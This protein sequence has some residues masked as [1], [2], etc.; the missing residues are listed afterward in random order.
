[1]SNGP[2]ISIRMES[3]RSYAKTM[4]SLHDRL[5]VITGDSDSGKSNIVRNVRS[6]IEGDSIGAVQ[7]FQR[8]ET[9]Q[10]S[11]RFDDVTISMNKGAGDNSY[12]ILSYSVPSPL[13][14]APVGD[15]Q[16]FTSVGSGVPD[17]VKRALNMGE[18]DLGNG[19]SLMLSI[20]Q[21]RGES[22]AID[23][24][25]ATCARIIGMVSGLDVVYG[26][27]ELSE[28]AR[29]DATKAKDT[30]R[31]ECRAAAVRVRTAARLAAR[32]RA[33][34]AGAAAARRIRDAGDGYEQAATRVRDVA[35][36]A[37]SAARW[38]QQASGRAERARTALNG[39]G[40]GQ[41]PAIS[42]QLGDAA[43]V[44]V[45]AAAA[46]DAATELQNANAAAA[47][48]RDELAEAERE[49]HA[50]VDVECPLCHRTGEQ[51]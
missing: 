14:T 17:P 24:T 35:A 31:A 21:Q 3:A 8:T 20:A 18:V 32:G 39:L 51:P 25:G 16:H 5:N 37:I 19:Q 49:V 38:Y 10:V 12:S 26:A 28:R 33:G 7:A 4:L 15:R 50:L 40:G 34:A 6:V 46:R 22:F 29:R 30:A 41:L 36:G 13:A 11:L 48:V 9:A 44:R 45:A 2:L 47:R 1:M 23:G 43:R 42:D 27:I